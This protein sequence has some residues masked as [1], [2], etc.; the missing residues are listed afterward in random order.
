MSTQY[1]TDIPFSASNNQ[2]AFKLLELPPELLALLESGN[3]PTFVQSTPFL[4]YI[5]FLFHIT[6]YPQP[7]N[8]ILS[9]HRNHPWLRHPNIHYDQLFEPSQKI[10]TTPKEHLESNND[11]RAQ[12][13]SADGHR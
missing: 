4:R 9:F 6:N 12:H 7:H 5:L 13:H 11:P 8:N 10:P 3:P 1:N 2:Q